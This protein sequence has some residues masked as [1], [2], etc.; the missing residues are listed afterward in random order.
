MAD[1]PQ[2]RI[3]G[4]GVLIALLCLVA[5]IAGVAWWLNRPN[6]SAPPP[7]PALVDL[8]VVCLGRVDGEK[9]VIE[10]EPAMPGKVVKVTENIEGKH[11]DANQALLELD[12]RSIQLRV[13]EAEAGIKAAEIDVEAARQELKLYPIRKTNQ[14]A[15][16]A[17]ATDRVLTTRRLFEEKKAA[18]TFGTVTPA[19]LAAAESEVK[20]SEHLEGAEKARLEE[21]KLSDPTLKLRAAEVKQT[22]ASI[23][24]SRAL[25][26]LDDCVL[27]APVAGIVLRMQVSVGESLA[28]GVSIQPIVFRPDGPLVVRAEI[29]QEFIGRVTRGMRASVRDDARGDSQTWTGTVQSVGQLVAPKKSILREPGEVND[30]RTVECVIALDGNPTGLLVGQRMRVRISRE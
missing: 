28:P 10:L 30:V 1:Y 16:V 19:E 24:H 2:R 29:Q 21:L 22:L 4:L 11:V 13:K 3:P 17:A 27:R 6:G 7:S 20:Q 23:A 8:D 25:K 5:P 14:E 18:R 15:A 12:N 9:P 26:A